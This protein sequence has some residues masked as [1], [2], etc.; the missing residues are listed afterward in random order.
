MKDSVLARLAQEFKEHRRP[1][2]FELRGRIRNSGTRTEAV[3]RLL[4]TALQIL[5]LEIMC[6]FTQL[7]EKLKDNTQLR[8]LELGRCSPVCVYLDT[9]ASA[10]A[11]NMTLQLLTLSL[12]MSW[13]P[14]T[15]SSWKHLGALVNNSRGLETLCLRDSCLGIHAVSPI[16]EAL[17]SNA[18]LQTL[19]LKG[20]GF[21]C[22]DALMF[23]RALSR[24]ASSCTTLKLGVVTGKVCEQGQFFREILTTGL[25]DRV[26][27]VFSSF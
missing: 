26:H 3:S 24:N 5:R 6:D 7:F 8:E 13:M 18:N 15:S 14:R 10:L 25:G 17:R 12:D 9:L 20:C 4:D 22:T 23:V 2:E 11:Q 21:S 19:N 16:C 1:R 27:W